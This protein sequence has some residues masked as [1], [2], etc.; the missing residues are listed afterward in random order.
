VGGGGQGGRAAGGPGSRAARGQG[1]MLRGAR[2]PRHR[3]PGGHAQEARGR[4]LG[5]KEARCR[6][7]GRAQGR[8]RG[9]PGTRAGKGKG[10]GEGERG[11]GS[12]PWD[13][14][15]GDNRPPDHLGQRGGRERWKKG[16]GSCCAGKPSEIER[17]AHMGVWGARGR[18]GLG[19]VGLGWV[20]GQDGSP[21][22][23]RPLIGIQLRIEIR[24][25]VRQ[26]HD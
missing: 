7:W 16:R 11:E 6:G 20:V 18:A 1:A 12:S 9:G 14:K 13:P 4:T 5:A 23:T 22:R 25:E 15:T 2:E 21:Q 10:E 19:W 8:V 17:G 3:G 24:N 26:T